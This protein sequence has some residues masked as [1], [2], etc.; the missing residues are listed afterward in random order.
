MRFLAHACPVSST[1]RWI[2]HVVIGLALCPWARPVRDGDGLRI[3]Q[4]DTRSPSAALLEEIQLLLDD[5]E[6]ETTVLVMPRHLNDDFLEFTQWLSEVDAW[7]QSEGLDDE[8]L[9]VGFHPKHVFA[10]ESE[11]DASNWTNRSPYPAV[12]ILRQQSVT[13]AVDTH[14]NT[15]KIAHDNREALQALGQPRLA[16]MVEWCVSAEGP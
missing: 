5:T 7:I 15:V 6:V 11:D 12:H 1:K 8:F 2:D 16:Q 13:E 9:L 4:T 14:P 3:A 10:G